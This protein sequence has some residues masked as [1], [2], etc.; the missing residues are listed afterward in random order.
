M[1]LNSEAHSSNT[2]R[3][4]PVSS[5][6]FGPSSCHTVGSKAQ[7][8]ELA[9]LNSQALS[10]AFCASNKPWSISVGL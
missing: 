7:L 5:T 8:S 9:Q 10:A 6:Y 4:T 3:P 2:P 1:V